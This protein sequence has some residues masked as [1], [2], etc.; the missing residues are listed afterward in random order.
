MARLTLSVLTV[1]GA[2]AG[3][4]TPAP[5]AIDLSGHVRGLDGSGIDGLDVSLAIAG[6]S[7]T[8]DTSGFWS[9]QSSTG[10][11]ERAYHPVGPDARHLLLARD[12]HLQVGFSGLDALGRGLHGRLPSGSIPRVTGRTFAASAVDTVVYSI[13]G[14]RL[15]VQP[16]YKYDTL[17]LVWILGDTT[18]QGGTG[19]S[20]N[21]TTS[22]PATYTGS[23]TISGSLS[24]YTYQATV[25]SIT[26]TKLKTATDPS[27]RGSGVANVTL[28]YSGCDH[29]IS[30]SAALDSSSLLQIYG[31]IGVQTTATYANKYV[32]VAE[33][34]TTIQTTCFGSPL[35]LPV[36]AAAVI[37]CPTDIGGL[38]SWTNI[39]SLAG[40]GS[41]I[42]CESLYSTTGTWS[43]TG[44]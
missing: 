20:G 44:H 42:N 2:M 26:F 6:L 28:T 35:S 27:Y 43:L 5:L 21:D 7:T 36:A 38:P 11:V 34:D 22:Y 19:G 29:P 3:S 18:G 41:W 25:P 9:L 37:G 17:G 30:F 15:G 8:T 10:L 24:V 14:V 39:K 13:V 23:L 33:V 40:T 16:L 1:L 12:G 4:A 31:P 32:I